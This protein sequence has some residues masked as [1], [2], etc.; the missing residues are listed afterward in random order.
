MPIGY[1]RRLDTEIEVIKDTK[2]LDPMKVAQ[3]WFP[4]AVDLFL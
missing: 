2:N 1:P 4:F 3:R